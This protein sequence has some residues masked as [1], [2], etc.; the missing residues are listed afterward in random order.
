MITFI[1]AQ[2]ILSILLAFGVP[3]ITIDKVKDILIPQSATTTVAVVPPVITPV[4][5]NEPVY[6]GSTV[7][8]TPAPIIPMIESPVM[9]E[10]QAVINKQGGAGA[11]EDIEIHYKENGKEV[12]GASIDISVS[13]G[14]FIIPG[15][16]GRDVGAGTKTNT[17][18]LKN[19]EHGT[20]A[21]YITG[22]IDYT[23]DNTNGK[24][25]SGAIIT[26]TAGGIT[27]TIQGRP[28]Y[29]VII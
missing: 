3:Q 7:N 16:V 27:K 29:K 17:I 24:F 19:G 1:Q 20:H 9:K 28:I 22:G 25:I 15:Q 2:A 23:G 14:Y 13:D 18:T 5:Q 26:I 10:L 6:F 8:N 4:I 21:I 12:I 11:M